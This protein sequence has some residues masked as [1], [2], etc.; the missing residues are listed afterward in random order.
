LS[1]GYFGIEI[2]GPNEPIHDEKRAIFTRNSS[3]PESLFFQR[4][5]KTS[6][7]DDFEEMTVIVKPDGA[8]TYCSPPP[9]NGYKDLKPYMGNFSTDYFTYWPD[10]KSYDNVDW[11]VPGSSVGNG[12]LA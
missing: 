10:R 2:R 3:H 7:T 11:Q 1:Q 6:N 8:V 5:G 12:M 4:P 9:W